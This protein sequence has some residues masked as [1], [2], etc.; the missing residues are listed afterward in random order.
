[1]NT[2]PFDNNNESQ[3]Y[4]PCVVSV[5]LYG[6]GTST[7]FGRVDDGPLYTILVEHNL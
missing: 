1:M 5:S 3:I 6:L 4:V 2:L 7:N